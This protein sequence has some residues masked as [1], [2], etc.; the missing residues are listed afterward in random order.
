MK[1]RQAK[2]KEK[3]ERIRREGEGKIR[4]LKGIYKGKRSKVREGLKRKAGQ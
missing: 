1:G 2:A 3:R 4:K